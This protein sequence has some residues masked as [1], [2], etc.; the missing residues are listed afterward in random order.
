MSEIDRVEPVQPRVGANRNLAQ[1]SPSA[2]FAAGVNG[3][4]ALRAD[5]EVRLVSAIQKDLHSVLALRN[6]GRRRLKFWNFIAWEV[7]TNS[8]ASPNAMDLPR[9]DLPGIE[10]KRHLD[11]LPGPHVF[12]VLLVISCKQ[13]AI[14]VHNQRRDSANPVNAGHHSWADLQIDNASVLRSHQRRVVQIV[15]CLTKL[16]FD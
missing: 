1:R 4:S 14:G 15:P 10:I 13:V 3:G 12:E 5:R 6:V 16:R 8:I 11:R 2:V 9:K 7:L